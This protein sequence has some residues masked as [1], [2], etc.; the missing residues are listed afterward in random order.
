MLGSRLEHIN[1]QSSLIISVFSVPQL[2][3]MNRFLG[4]GHCFEKPI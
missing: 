4:Q 3:K 2:I 1:R